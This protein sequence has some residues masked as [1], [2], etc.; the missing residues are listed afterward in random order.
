LSNDLDKFI[1]K[2]NELGVF[3]VKSMYLDLVEG[4]TIFLRKYL[5]KLKLPLKIKIFMW[6]LNKKVLLTKDNLLSVIEKGVKNIVTVM[7]LKL[8]TFI[9]NLSLCEDYLAYDVLNI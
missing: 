7:N 1:W 9:F 4:H 8:S 3:T 5:W 6:F 2:L